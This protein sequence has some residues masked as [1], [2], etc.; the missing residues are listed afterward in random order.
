MEK[1]L[2]DIMIAHSWGKKDLSGSSERAYFAVL[3]R[4]TE[5]CSVLEDS[6]QTWTSVLS[7]LRSLGSSS[8]EESNSSIQMGS[9]D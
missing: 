5:E 9:L 8:S 2:L 4:E 6:F 3:K 7:G 1:L